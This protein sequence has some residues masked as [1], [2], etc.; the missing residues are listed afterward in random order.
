LIPLGLGL[1]V[2]GAIV[3]SLPDDDERLFSLSETHGPSP[4]DAVGI[5]LALA[6]WGVLLG[7]LWR[8]RDRLARPAPLVAGGVVFA[9]GAAILAVA[10]A[11]DAGWWWLLGAALMASV[12]AVA[13][14]LVVLGET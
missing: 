11:T 8:G 3:V 5:V 4:L 7:A 14:T 2:V 12:Q 10:I 6:G 13:L 9:I 1:L